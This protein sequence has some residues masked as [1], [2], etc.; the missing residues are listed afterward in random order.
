MLLSS[1]HQVNPNSVASQLCVGWC[2]FKGLS[3]QSSNGPHALREPYGWPVTPTCLINTFCWDGAAYQEAALDSCVQSLWI[4][5]SINKNIYRPLKYGQ[6][7]FFPL[8]PPLVIQSFSFHFL[9]QHVLLRKTLTFL[10]VADTIK[11]L[12]RTKVRLMM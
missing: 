2:I 4:K 10:N 1:L 6:P 9:Q 8:T 12:F 3:W 11:G 7:C 5:R